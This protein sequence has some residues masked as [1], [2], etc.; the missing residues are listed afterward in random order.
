MLEMFARKTID[1]TKMKSSN[2]LRKPKNCPMSVFILCLR[3]LIG[4]SSLMPSLEQVSEALANFQNSAVRFD[5]NLDELLE[6]EYM[7]EREIVFDERV[8]ISDDLVP[9]SNSQTEFSFKSFRPG[10]DNASLVRI[11]ETGEFTIYKFV[12]EDTFSKNI[13]IE[14]NWLFK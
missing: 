4:V 10:F 8:E 13:V 2:F 1:F 11:G 14:S 6:N 3:C 9:I 12:R 5:I 7:N